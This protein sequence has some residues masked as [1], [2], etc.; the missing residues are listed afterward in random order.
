M[1][2]FESRFVFDPILYKASP[3]RTLWSASNSADDK[4]VL[5]PSSSWLYR[6]NLSIHTSSYNM[7]LRIDG[8]EHLHPGC[9]FDMQM[10]FCIKKLKESDHIFCSY[11]LDHAL[12]TRGQ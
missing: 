4:L 8:M 5:V 9:H 3:S 2:S 10:E 6:P 7:R 1:K 12:R 11:W